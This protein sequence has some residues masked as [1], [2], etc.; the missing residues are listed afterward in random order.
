MKNLL[1]LVVIFLCVCR[2]EAQSLA[3]HEVAKG[4]PS[5]SAPSIPETAYWL[6]DYVKHRSITGHERNAGKYFSNLCQDL[7][8]SVRVLN[9]NEDSYN[10]AASLYPLESNKKNIIFLNHI[11]VVEAA[12]SASWQL[13]PFSGIIKDGF[14]WGRGSYD[15]KGMA[16]MQLAAL[17]EFKKQHGSEDL[18]FNIT[19]LSVSGE[20]TLGAKGA[21]LVTDECWDCLNPYM[22]VGEGPSVGVH[23]VFKGNMEQQLFPIAVVNKRVLWLDLNVEMHT[24]GHASAKTGESAMKIMTR[25]TNRLNRKFKDEMIFNETNK[26]MMLET[27]KVQK[28][29]AGMMMRY[30]ARNAESLPFII[31]LILKAIDPATLSSFCNTANNTGIESEGKAYNSIPQ[32]VWARMDCRLMPGVKDTDFIANLKKIIKD[33]RV[34]ISIAYQVGGSEPSSTN[35]EGYTA[36]KNAILENYPKAAVFPTLPGGGSDCSFFRAKGVPVF[37]V[38]P[39]LFT[40]KLLH[41]VHGT[42]ERFPIDMLDKGTKTYLSFLENMR[43]Q[44]E[45]QMLDPKIVTKPKP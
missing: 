44:Q 34:K 8:L 11:D 22:V 4:A 23:Q 39:V 33:D 26:A 38:I 40:K 15:N 6:S 45:D 36:L 20:E 30:A 3:Y 16:V 37:S 19:L 21:K 42:D 35:H 32:K 24:H 41:T 31:K 7:G 14:V 29:I 27:G 1:L 10:F 28:G 2:V 13:P 17:R 25:A 18:P 5:H 9:D 12:D 43:S